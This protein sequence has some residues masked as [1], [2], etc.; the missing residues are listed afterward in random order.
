MKQKVIAFPGLVKRANEYMVNYQYQEAVKLFDQL[1]AMNNLTTEELAVY[2]FALVEVKRYEEAKEL[3]EIIMAK[4]TA[5]YWDVVELYIKASMQL[6]N[7]QQVEKLITTLID[8]KA[9]PKERYEHFRQLHSLNAKIAKQMAVPDVTATAFFA[10][11]IDKQ[12]AQLYE[13]QTIPI[14]KR[15]DTIVAIIEDPKAHP[16]VQSLALLLLVEQGVATTVTITKFNQTRTV[17]TETLVLPTAMPQFKAVMAMI[18]QAL[19]QDPTA[20]E[21]AKQ[22]IVKHAI[23]TYPLEWQPFATDDIAIGY[24]QFI[25]E[26]FGKVQEVDV[27]VQHYLQKLEAAAMVYD[28]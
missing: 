3:C 22:I 2:A 26:L 27:E 20:L 18:E 25:E 11:S 19:M 8:D 10:Q 12:L 17:A 7:Y 4:K 14:M 21:M 5:A 1:Y 13:W 16:M 6:K 28:V 15:K 9:V 23:M 24:Q